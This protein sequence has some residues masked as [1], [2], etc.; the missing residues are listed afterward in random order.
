MF[1]CKKSLCKEDMKNNCAHNY[2]A[3][4]KNHILIKAG[5]PYGIKAVGSTYK[6]GQKVKGSIFIL[7]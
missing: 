4:Q 7:F 5:C 3:K 1:L 2:L 6:D